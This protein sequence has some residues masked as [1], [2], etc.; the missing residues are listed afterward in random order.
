MI[1]ISIAIHHIGLSNIDSSSS[2]TSVV[3][4]VLDTY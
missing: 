2:Y 4:L 3:A 1:A